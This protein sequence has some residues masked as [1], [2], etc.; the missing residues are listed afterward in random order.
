[1]LNNQTNSFIKKLLNEFHFILKNKSP[2]ISA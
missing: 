2:F 1:M